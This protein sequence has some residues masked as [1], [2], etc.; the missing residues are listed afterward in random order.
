M[1]NS[2]LTTTRNWNAN[3]I[4]KDANLINQPTLLI[5][6]D[7]DTVIPRINGEKLYDRILN[8]RYVVFNNCGHL[9]HEEKSDIFTQLVLEFC[10]N[11]KG[12]IESDRK[13]VELKQVKG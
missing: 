1:H 11:R 12:R 7:N 6:G 13:D 8:S 5:W 2:L 4:E 3:R 10:G 9:P